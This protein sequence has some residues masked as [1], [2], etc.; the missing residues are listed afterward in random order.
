MWSTP[1]NTILQPKDTIHPPHSLLS[2]NSTIHNEALGIF[3]QDTR[4]EVRCAMH[5]P[6]HSTSHPT[7]W[8]DEALRRCFCWRRIKHVDV[9]APIDG[10][11]FEQ[12][13]PLHIWKHVKH[14]LLDVTVRPGE[15]QA[16]ASKIRH[17]GSWLNNYRGLSSLGVKLFHYR[18]QALLNGVCADLG[19]ILEAF[20]TLRCRG[21]VKEIVLFAVDLPR[22][23]KLEAWA[24]IGQAMKRIVGYVSRTRLQQRKSH[25]LT[26]SQ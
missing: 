25:S 7:P 12:L 5:F 16:V 26:T 24:L 13:P 6:S 22:S 20:E 1:R 4:V 17:I 10:P 3:L 21:R 2:T 23:R 9:R 14:L 11:G 15:A 18:R 8:L 19:T